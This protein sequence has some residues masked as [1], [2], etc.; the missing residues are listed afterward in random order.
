MPSTA[1]ITGATF[2]LQLTVI[3]TVA[4]L[5]PFKVYVNVSADPA[6]SLQ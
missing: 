6:G 4:T 1:P 5:P 2:V 3:D